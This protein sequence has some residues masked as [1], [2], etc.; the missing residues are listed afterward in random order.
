MNTNSAKGKVSFSVF[1]IFIRVY[2]M[3]GPIV[4]FIFLRSLDLDMDRNANVS[5]HC[6]FISYILSFLVLLFAGISQLITGSRK[7]A[8]WSFGFAGIA[9]LWIIVWLFV[10]IPAILSI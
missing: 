8:Y 6:V 7:S 2:A 9:L 4:V 1:L 5:G 10:F 3:I